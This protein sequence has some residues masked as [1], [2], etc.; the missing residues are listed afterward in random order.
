MPFLM[1][2]NFI[3]TIEMMCVRYPRYRLRRIETTFYSDII[4][5]RLFSPSSHSYIY[6]T[7]KQKPSQVILSLYL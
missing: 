3:I 6:L 4:L 5:G 2:S 7:I 1:E